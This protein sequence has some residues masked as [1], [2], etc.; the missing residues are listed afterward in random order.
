VPVARPID[1]ACAAA[2]VR[3]RAAEAVAFAEPWAAAW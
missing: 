3:E 1:A 2:M